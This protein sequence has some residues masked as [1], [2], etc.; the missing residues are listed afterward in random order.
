MKNEESMRC[1]LRTSTMIAMKEGANESIYAIICNDD[2]AVRND[3]RGYLREYAQAHSA[4][5]TISEYGSA[6]A[7]LESHEDFDVLFLD[8]Y[9]E[10]MEGTEA[11]QLLDEEK[12]K[13]IVFL[14]ISESHAIEAFQLGVAHYLL[15]PVTSKG[16]IEALERCIA[17]RTTEEARILSVRTTD[18]V[19]SFPMGSIR[20]IEAQDKTCTIT[21]ADGDWR[22]YAPL[23]S[24]EE[25]LDD[26]CFF[27]VHRSYIV[28]MRYI[29]TIYHDRVVMDD[30]AV[31]NVSRGRRHEMKRRY[32]DFMFAIARGDLA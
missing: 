23:S 12:R 11:A 2:P 17:E 32:Q 10:G 6:E 27:R 29:K 15:K 1:S 9:M 26:R 28:N 14:T 22:A 19:I 5:M 20:M 21:T 13:R 16:V 24:L 3:V 7:L 31:I 8:I 18:G 30:G 25:Q 4:D